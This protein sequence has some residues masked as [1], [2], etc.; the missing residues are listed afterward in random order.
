MSKEDSMAEEYKRKISGEEAKDRYIMIVKHALDFF[1]KI[2]KPFKLKIKEKE[3][4]TF[5][6]TVD[7]YTM[8][9]KKPQHS[10]RIT[11][12]PFWDTFSFHFGQ[13]VIITKTSEKEFTLS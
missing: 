3:F 10:Y 12:K 4:E 2:G 1:P 5:I 13:T 9:P 6:E 7:V 8:G 11:A